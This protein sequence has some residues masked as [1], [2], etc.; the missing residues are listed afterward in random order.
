MSKPYYTKE[1]L[2]VKYKL[3]L[4]SAMMSGE[5]R[6]IVH[7]RCMLK[8]NE[9]DPEKDELYQLILQH[10][11]DVGQSQQPF[12]EKKEEKKDYLKGA[13]RWYP[14]KK[15]GEWVPETASTCAKCGAP[16]AVQLENQEIEIVIEIEPIPGADHIRKN[17]RIQ[18]KTPL[19][20]IIAT[21]VDEGTI[22][23][24]EYDEVGIIRTSSNDEAAE[25]HD[26]KNCWKQ[27]PDYQPGDIVLVKRQLSY[28]EKSLAHL[29]YIE[30]Q[31]SDAQLLCERELAVILPRKKIFPTTKHIRVLACAGKAG[32]IKELGIYSAEFENYPKTDI[33]FENGTIP[34][35][36]LALE[37]EDRPLVIT[38]YLE[39]YP[40][41][42][43]VRF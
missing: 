18:P 33:P 16:F 30:E 38:H 7:Y 23:E 35:D 1:E 28:A 36:A 25:A 8:M 32:I 17:L 42:N 15:C 34:V 13:V 24:G 41:E 26:N 22:N 11:R 43:D 12:Q 37:L 10:A 20:T 3:A 2:D 9:E 29:S 27:Y 4:Y 5:I 31:Y 40:Y 14:C 39:T 19:R 21:L 6:G